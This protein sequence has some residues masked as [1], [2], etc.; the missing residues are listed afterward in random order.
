MILQERDKHPRGCQC[1][2]QAP[3]PERS[4]VKMNCD[5]DPYQ[6]SEKNKA[7]AEPC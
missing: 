7:L 2:T 6:N 3:T 5:Y 1:N 4:Q